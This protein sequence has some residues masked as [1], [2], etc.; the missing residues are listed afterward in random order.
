MSYLVLVIYWIL[1]VLST[2]IV[3]YYNNKKHAYRKIFAEEVPLSNIIRD[4]NNDTYL[5]RTNAY[6]SVDILYLNHIV[7]C[8]I[9]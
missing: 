2:Y 4:F 8:L 3:R 6:S 9:F 5:I 7:C 1:S